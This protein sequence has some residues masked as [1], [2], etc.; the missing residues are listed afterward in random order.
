MCALRNVLANDSKIVRYLVAPLMFIT[1]S[2][3]GMN[4]PVAVN[5]TK[6]R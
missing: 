2:L 1:A 6:I 4:K 3:V 5:V